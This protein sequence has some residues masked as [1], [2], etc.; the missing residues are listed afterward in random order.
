[1]SNRLI[2][3]GRV[4]LIPDPD[5]ALKASQAF[6]VNEAQTARVTHLG[7][8]CFGFWSIIRNGIQGFADML[9]TAIQIRDLSTMSDKSLADIGLRRDQLPQLFNKSEVD[10]LMGHRR[11]I[12]LNDS[13]R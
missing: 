7:E 4:P 9:E 5:V 8:V 1:V 11:S 6:S 12:P 3:I 13:E 10:G 2:Q